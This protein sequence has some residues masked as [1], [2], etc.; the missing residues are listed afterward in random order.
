MNILISNLIKFPAIDGI[1]ASFLSPY[2]N[3]GVYMP[4]FPSIA[5]VRAIPP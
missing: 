4:P 2:K 3:G 5:T 1:N